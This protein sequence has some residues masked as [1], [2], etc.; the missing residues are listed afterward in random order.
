MECK[1]QLCAIFERV[2]LLQLDMRLGAFV[3]AL[4]AGDFGA[5]AVD[6]SGRIS[7]GFI[8]SVGSVAGAV[9]DGV[10]TGLR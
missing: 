5:T 9:A 10:V 7:S 8:T 3:A 4:I 1:L 6:D 2:V